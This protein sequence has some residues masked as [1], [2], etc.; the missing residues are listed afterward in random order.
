MECVDLN[1]IKCLG[2]SS[3]NLQNVKVF[4]QSLLTAQFKGKADFF[5]SKRLTGFW[6]RNKKT[7]RQ[8]V[9]ATL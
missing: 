6:P 4:Y 9:K 3:F 8:S 1:K 5:V 7:K 2:N